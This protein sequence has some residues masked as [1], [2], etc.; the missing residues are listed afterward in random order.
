M[1]DTV[2]CVL[3]AQ[4][5][6]NI[7]SLIKFFSSLILNIGYCLSIHI[8]MLFILP[9]KCPFHKSPCQN[10]HI[11]NKGIHTC[12]KKLGYKEPLWQGLWGHGAAG[13]E[14]GV[15]IKPRH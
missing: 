13:G 11:L 15:S 4:L 8:F 6:V 7:S 12:I 14:Q 1:A 3:K 5:S 9:Q 2:K 10:T